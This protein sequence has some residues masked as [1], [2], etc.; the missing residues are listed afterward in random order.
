M[1]LVLQSVPL[2]RLY[3]LCLTKTLFIYVYSYFYLEHTVKEHAN[4]HNRWLYVF[5]MSNIR[6]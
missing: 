2:T 4:T 6:V 1:D 3:I 5:G